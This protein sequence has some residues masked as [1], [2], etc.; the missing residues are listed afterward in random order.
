[1]P[2]IIETLKIPL[3]SAPSFVVNNAVDFVVL[4]T[5]QQ[6]LYNGSNNRWFVHGDNLIILSIGYYMPESFVLA[7]RAAG[8]PNFPL[9]EFTLGSDDPTLANYQTVQPF[10]SGG[11]ID[12]PFP[13]YE[14]SIGTYINAVQYLQD[15][16]FALLATLG[17]AANDVRISMINVPADLN[18]DT[19]HVIPFI[20][21][22][23]NK[24]MF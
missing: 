10:G 3:N 2:E 20:K 19:I 22:L 7:E 4:N 23:H 16:Q 6:I 11:T 8:A 12:I 15:D 17:G 14:M 9:M 18:G 5:S 24:N 21:V 1:M 13:N